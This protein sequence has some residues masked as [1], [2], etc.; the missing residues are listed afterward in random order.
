M[1]QQTY[2]F[3]SMDGG[4]FRLSMSWQVFSTLFLC[5][6]TILLLNAVFGL[7]Y[8]NYSV[9]QN[10]WDI[11]HLLSAFHSFALVLLLVR[12]LNTRIESQLSWSRSLG[13][14]I[15]Y[16]LVL[17]VLISIVAISLINLVMDA[18]VYQVDFIRLLDQVITVVVTSF[19]I[20]LVLL[21]DFGIILLNKWKQSATEAEKFKKENMEFRFDMLRNQVNPHFLFNSLNT[22]ASLIY[23][24][25]DQASDFVRQLAKV[26][27][28]VLENKDKEL[29]TLQEEHDFLKS[30]LYL[31]QIRFAQG[32]QINL[33]LDLENKGLLAPMTVQ[34]LVENAIKHNIV[35]AS[36]PLKISI[37]TDEE[38]SLVVANTLQKKISPEPSTKT[39][40][41]NIKNRYAFL[42]DKEVEI[43]ETTENY[44]VRVPLIFDETQ[45]K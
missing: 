1:Q 34:L 23:E 44:T 10:T 13:K 20:S 21:S 33:Q 37:Y 9:L 41:A 26:Y 27:R 2:I 18:L 3:G 43:L 25:Q 22:L 36:K 16:H 11:K 4:R 17:P 35:S 30:Y 32:L 12:W 31:L 5:L 29:I 40:L 38:N 19:G 6:I 24:N 8:R 14:Q 15:L 7:V 28:Y 45:E 42:T 39:G